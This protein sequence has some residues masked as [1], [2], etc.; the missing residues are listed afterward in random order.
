VEVVPKDPYGNFIGPGHT[1]EVNINY[2]KEKSNRPIKLNDRLDGTYKGEIRISPRGLKTGVQLVFTID[3]KFFTTVAKIPGFKKRSLGIYAGVGIPAYSFSKGRNIDINPGCHL[4]YQLSPQFSLVGMVGYNHFR[5]DSSSNEDMEMQWW[6]ISAN[7]QSEVVKVPFRIYVDV[8]PGIYIS[9][10][11][12]FTPGFNFGIGAAYS[13]K[14]D[15]GIE[16][17]ANFHHLFT[18]GVLDP[19]FLVTYARLVYHF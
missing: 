5:S 11:G 3:G 2:K 7:L 1:V 17:G 9:G 6:N 12:V 14:A 19:N 13:L 15:W 18:K 4:G 16:L 10:S 8:G